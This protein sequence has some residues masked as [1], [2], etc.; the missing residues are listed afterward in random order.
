MFYIDNILNMTP[1][2]KVTKAKV[3]I[4]DYIKLKHT[5]QERKPSTKENNNLQSGRK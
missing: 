4:L 2:A 5:A 1:K 3:N